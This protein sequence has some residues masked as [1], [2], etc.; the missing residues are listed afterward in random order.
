MQET[1]EQKIKRANEMGMRRWRE[2]M[3]R[4]KGLPPHM[5]AR[6]TD[7]GAQPLDSHIP[8]RHQFRFRP[9]KPQPRG[10]RRQRCKSAECAS[11]A[12][13]CEGEETNVRIR[14]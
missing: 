1:I 9:H 7:G 4:E 11:C 2:R 10:M 6:L 12:R 3:I 8:A 5:L 14:T 13:H